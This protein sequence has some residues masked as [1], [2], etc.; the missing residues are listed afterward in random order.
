[1]KKKMFSVSDYP[2]YTNNYDGDQY[3]ME[4]TTIKYE[5]GMDNN[6]MHSEE[7]SLDNDRNNYNNDENGDSEQPYEQ[8]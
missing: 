4:N 2:D 1:M 6:Q 7:N 5:K 8:Y 3:D